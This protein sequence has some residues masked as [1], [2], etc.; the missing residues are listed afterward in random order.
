VPQRP[1]LAVKVGNYTGDRP[2]AGLNQADL[3]VEEPVEG[4]ITRLVA[5]FQCQAPTEV[6]DLRS[7]REPDVAILSQLSHPLFAHAG[8]I[9]PVLNLIADAPV[10]DV[11]VLRDATGVFH[12]D[13]RTSPYD[14]FVTPSALWAADAG[15]R[16]PPAPVFTY[17]PALPAGAVAGSG[18]SVHVPFS[19]TSDVTWT[20]DAATGRY[21]RS[22]AGERDVLVDGTQTAAVDV[23]VET[24]ET[25]AGPW[26]ENSEGALEVEVQATGSGPVTVLEGGAAVTGTWTRSSVTSPATLTTSG[27]RPLTLLPGNAWIELVPQGVDVT[28]TAA[29]AGTAPTTATGA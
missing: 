6:G 26:V 28:T 3:V 20:W 5:V 12:P 17:S 19:S 11:D 4:A 10:T 9:D 27:G 14:T 16:T 24:V 29:P 7:A 2:S 1:A 23:V 13:G 25:F 22:Y 8:G 18:A 15:D 21:L